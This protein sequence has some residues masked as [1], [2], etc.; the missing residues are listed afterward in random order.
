MNWLNYHHLLYFWV[1]AKEGSIA[2]ASTV[3]RL[4]HP[5]ISG[6]I[7]RLEE[8][9][10]EKLFEH[11]GRALVLTDSGRIAFGYAEEIFALGD[12][13]MET[14]KGRPP[15]RPI[16]LVVGLSAS[17]PMPIVYQM[18]QPALA[19][20]ERVQIFCREGR[21]A[22]AFLGNLA[23]QAVD[24]VL[25]DAPATA[26]IGLQVFN[27]LLGECGTAF[28]AKAD[29]AKSLRRR[30]PDSLEGAPFVLPGTNSGMYRALKQWFEDQ[31]LRPKIVAEVD[32]PSL[33]KE[34]AATGRGVVAMPDVA[35][36]DIQ[37]RF[38]VSLVGK[39]TALRQRFYAIS[40]ER[41]IKHPAVVA[42][43]DASRKKIFAQA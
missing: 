8:V 43:C 23:V 14:L 13:F 24:V 27:H 37:G 2:R 7:H 21:S 36:D 33:L 41:K 6:Q 4:A 15:G 38:K 34:F 19:L 9:L 5:T 20:D 1:V 17:L 42:I 31:H 32:D 10:G 30:F 26:G 3:L 18:L 12:E 28:F 29:L 35:E 25:S 11:K 39:D 22:D 16:P 40:V